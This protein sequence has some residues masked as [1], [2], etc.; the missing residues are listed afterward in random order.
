MCYIAPH[1]R[2]SYYYWTFYFHLKGR[3]H[4]LRGTCWLTTQQ[5]TMAQ[6][7]L[8]P[9]GHGERTQGAE[10]LSAAFHGKYQQKAKPKHMQDSIP[11]IP[12]GK[13]SAA[14]AA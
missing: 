5:L 1:T 10:Q 4:R 2:I 11:G 3:T 9:V 14:A 13:W 6:T 7:D 12:T 8:G